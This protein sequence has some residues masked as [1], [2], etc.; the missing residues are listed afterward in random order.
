MNKPTPEGL[1]ILASSLR[2]RTVRHYTNRRN[3]DQASVLVD[4]HATE[5][6][7]DR[8]KLKAL[9]Q[10]MHH[11]YSIT[12]EGTDVDLAVRIG[13]LAKIALDEDARESE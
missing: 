12:Q 11:V 3:L 2:N 10:T 9:R 4:H 5:W 6:E 1:R 8:A 13:N 7:S